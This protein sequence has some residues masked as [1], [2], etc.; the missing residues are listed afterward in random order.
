MKRIGGGTFGHVLVDPTC[1]KTVIKRTK[2][3]HEPGEEHTRRT[4]FIRECLTL[5]KVS[6]PNVLVLFRVMPHEIHMPRAIL[7]LWKWC[8]AYG[9]DGYIELDKQLA[10]SSDLLSGTRHL[11][12]S[13]FMHRDIKPENLLLI[14]SYS[15]PVLQLADFG[16]SVPLS[17]RSYTIVAGTV[18]YSAPEQHNQY[19]TYNQSSDWWS[20]GLVMEFM[21][22]GRNPLVISNE[23]AFADPP[24][25]RA[26]QVK[27][28]WRR[29]WEPE[30]M[31]P[32]EMMIEDWIEHKNMIKRLLSISCYER[33]FDELPELYTR[34]GMK[35]APSHKRSKRARTE[36]SG[37][38]GVVYEFETSSHGSPCSGCSP[39]VEVSVPAVS[40]CPK[41]GV[42]GTLKEALDALTH[43]KHNVAKAATELFTEYFESDAPG[44]DPLL[45]I[46]AVVFWLAN[47]FEASTAEFMHADSVVK[48]FGLKH[49]DV[50]GAT[51]DS[52]PEL[53][54]KFVDFAYGVLSKIANARICKNSKRGW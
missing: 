50:P 19:G 38:K 31:W 11:H 41:L 3:V 27:L 29:V 43:N 21:R 20:C 13:G 1:S 48:M 15:R 2:R 23:D 30:C 54:D 24:C 5:S 32:E 37:G 17:D 42:S 35:T 49:G 46:S 52:D 39:L 10:W 18:A 25:A 4:H 40:R 9:Q 16:T 53:V 34:H 45:A 33:E 51:C 47:N 28:N 12:T 44:E 6:H 7:S 8:Q 36:T 22:T 26:F 14:C